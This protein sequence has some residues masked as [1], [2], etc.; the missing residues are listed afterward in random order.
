MLKLSETLGYREVCLTTRDTP[1][2]MINSKLHKGQ[3]MDISSRIDLLPPTPAKLLTDLSRYR[4][5]FDVIGV[6]C[7]SKLVARQAA[8]DHR[9]DLLNFP[10]NHK[11]CA[12]DSAEAELAS[13]S[14]TALEI[15]TAQL[16]KAKPQSLLYNLIQV[17]RA[18]ENAKRYDIPIVVS[19]GATSVYDIRS[20]RDLA[21]LM[22]LINLSGE[23]ALNSISKIPV[24]IVQRN[25]RKLDKDYVESGV[26]IIRKGS[27]NVCN[28]S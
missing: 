23:Q 9:V 16:V 7:Q 11:R 27:E 13:R 26:K 1:P 10:F 17:R 5:M 2:H 12:F 6:L 25:R 19:S 15:D 14:N 3:N 21:S 24:S 28:E 20:P 22:Q 18:I 4:K 8:K